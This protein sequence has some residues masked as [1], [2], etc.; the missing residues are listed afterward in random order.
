MNNIPIDRVILVL[1]DN[2]LYLDFW[3]YSSKIWKVNFGVTPTLF[4]VG[5]PS[6]KLTEQFGEVYILPEVNEVIVN[7]SRDWSVT[8][9]LFWGAAQFK[10]DVC[11]THGIDQAP[12]SDRFFKSIKKYDFN[13]DYV[14]GLADAYSIPNWYVSSHHIAKGSIFKEALSVQDR[15]QDEVKSVFSYRNNYGSMYNTGDFWGLDELHSSF[16]L[17]N[18]PD[19]K[20]H[21]G[22]KDLSL[23]RIDRAYHSSFNPDLLS[24]GYYSEIHAHRPYIKYKIFLDKISDLC[25]IYT[26]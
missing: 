21:S 10:D 24:Q 22:F 18:F 16:L 5:K 3:N 2:P 11:I 26:K 6:I 8:W 14:I 19:I 17:K 25:P 13:K 23:R 1:N 12:L 9:A 4:F 15:W 20:L 7:R